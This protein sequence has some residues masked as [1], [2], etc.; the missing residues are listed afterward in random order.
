LISPWTPLLLGFAGSLHCAGMCSP[1]VMAVTYNR[2]G[3]IHRVN[4][5]A[6]RIFTYC[7]YGA[8]AVV[9]G[10]AFE[11][12]Q[13]GE[14]ISV[15]LGVILLFVAI[16]GL[17][18]SFIPLISPTLSRLTRQLKLCFGYLLKIESPVS[19]FLLGMINGLLPCGLT[20]LALTYCFTLTGIEDGVSFMLLF[21]VGTLAV[22]LGFT[23]LLIRMVRTYNLSIQKVN[24]VLILIT[25]VLLIGRG[26]LHGQFQHGNHTA[27]KQEVICK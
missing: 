25:A 19:V 20:F 4:Y 27:V 3:F 26:L 12:A 16:S 18:V 5:N 7:I 1:L 21:G 11:L 10:S 14:I 15:A 6:G 2:K 9:L 8:F 23:S 17:N 22:M 13:Y 24:S